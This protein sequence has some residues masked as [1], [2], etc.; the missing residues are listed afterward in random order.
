MKTKKIPGADNP[1]KS[2]FSDI[3]YLTKYFWEIP[4]TKFFLIN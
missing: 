3:S 4:N 1:L 2:Y